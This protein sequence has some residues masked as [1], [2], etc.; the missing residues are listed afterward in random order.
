MDHCY[1]IGDPNVSFQERIYYSHW[2]N[3]SFS[4]DNGAK[5]ADGVAFTVHSPKMRDALRIVMRVCSTC[6]SLSAGSSPRRSERKEFG[7]I[8][9]R[10][11]STVINP[12]LMV[13]TC[14]KYTFLIY[15]NISLYLYLRFI[16][17]IENCVKR[18][19]LKVKGR[20]KLIEKSILFFNFNFNCIKIFEMI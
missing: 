3:R 14:W 11:F 5:G 15:E 4:G 6:I 19:I 2:A 10:N 16:L 7:F 20:V 13:C 17:R 18:Q 1:L 12:M 9:H 8:A